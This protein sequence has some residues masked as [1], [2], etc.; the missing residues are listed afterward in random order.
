MT[1]F[2]LVVKTGFEM[3]MYFTGICLAVGLLISTVMA[4]IMAVAVLCDAVRV[5]W[6][7]KRGEAA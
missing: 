7:R 5:S 1:G 3:L 2:A 6:S 4:F